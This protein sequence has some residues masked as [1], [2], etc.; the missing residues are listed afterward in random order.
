MFEVLWSV[1]EAGWLEAILAAESNSPGS[2]I[3]GEWIALEDAW[4]MGFLRFVNNGSPY[5]VFEAPETVEMLLIRAAH[6]ELPQIRGSSLS[7]ALAG[8]FRLPVLDFAVQMASAIG[9]V[10][11]YYTREQDGFL[12][13]QT[14]E[15]LRIWFVEQEWQVSIRHI[16]PDGFL[17]QFLVPASEFRPGIARFL[18]SFANAV[19]ERI[20]AFVEWETFRPIMAWR[21]PP[22]ASGAKS[23]PD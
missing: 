21:S 19:A 22:N 9:P 16:G 18:R 3:D 17:W 13:A 15:G 23:T 12:Y 2:P 6:P 4:F 11:F 10:D 8:R 1:D 7:T 5:P 14:M 20:P